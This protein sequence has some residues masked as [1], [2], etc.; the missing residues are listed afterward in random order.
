M[1]NQFIREA[2][3]I[4]FEVIVAAQINCSLPILVNFV[5]QVG[6]DPH[7]VLLMRCL[8]GDLEDTATLLFE[9]QV[10]CRITILV[11][12]GQDVLAASKIHI[13]PL[14]SPEECISDTLLLFTRICALFVEKEIGGCV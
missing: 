5:Q 1:H 11:L 6:L 12:E 13:R 2:A 7:P 14:I 3:N 10:N 4:L 8:E 9:H